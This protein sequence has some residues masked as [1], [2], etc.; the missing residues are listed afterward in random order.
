MLTRVKHKKTGNF[1]RIYDGAF[2]TINCT[3]E[4]DGQTMICYWS[5]DPKVNYTFV[6]EEKEFWEKFE[7]IEN[8]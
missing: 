6:R 3:N 5:E 4:Q 8:E 1:Y 2:K 7:R